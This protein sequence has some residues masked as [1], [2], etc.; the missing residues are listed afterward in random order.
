M[1]PE[2]NKPSS[3][4]KFTNLFRI[5]KNSF[6]TYNKNYILRILLL[7]VGSI[8]FI[9][10][11]PS[12]ISPYEYSMHVAFSEKWLYGINIIGT[13]GPLGFIGL[14]YYNHSTYLPMIIIN[15]TIYLA[16]IFLMWRFWRD[17]IGNDSSPVLWITAIF[18]ISIL[19]KPQSLAPVLFMP[20]I[21]INLF[22]LWHFINKRPLSL[23]RLI[24]LTIVLAVFV[25]V[26]AT[27]IF[28]IA[29]SIIAVAWDQTFR[30]KRFPWLIFVFIISIFFLWIL[31]GQKLFHLADYF[32]SSIDVITGYKDGM[33]TNHR[34]SWFSAPILIIISFSVTAYL[35]WILQ[36]HIGWRSIFPTGIFAAS[37]F[38]SFQHGFVRADRVHIVTAY[39]TF[40]ILLL[41]VLP[42]LKKL[43]YKEKSWLLLRKSL[44]IL[45]IIGIGGMSLV[46]SPRWRSLYLRPLEFYNLVSG[47]VSSLENM[48][49]ISSQKTKK[50]Y[51]IPKMK[52]PIGFYAEN[53]VLLTESYGLQSSLF[54]SVSAFGAYTP[55]I[56]LKNKKYIESTSGPATIILSSHFSIDR[57][58]PTVSDSLSVLALKSHFNAA[59]NTGKILVLERRLRPLELQLVKITEQNVTFNEDI[60]VPENNTAIFVKI[61][62]NQTLGG[63]ILNILYKPS[64]IFISI[65]QGGESEIFRLTTSMAKEG[66]LLSPLL[67]DLSA[68]Q[69]FYGLSCPKA[70]LKV[71]T[72]KITSPKWPKWEYDKQIRISFFRIVEN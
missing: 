25:L 41:L 29:L 9:H 6:S 71:E 30:W 65:N 46:S 66:M 49:T 61:E 43:I 15:I 24:P 12:Y 42:I 11:Y 16:C 56:S 8:Y 19:Q 52:E 2:H 44:I 20:Y 54:P 57:R 27:F 31:A 10:F 5:T 18:F 63:K 14:P 59:H 34:T 4:E 21:L 50:E 51:P 22:V 48:K 33:G 37:L 39:L 13:Y 35:W 38:V 3:L 40:F 32:I 60:N 17:I 26:K 64:P 69:C 28:L 53:L 1:I 62:I 67:N 7:L 58:Y 47:G 68:L 70:P 45:A 23:T 36:Q 55:S 72:F